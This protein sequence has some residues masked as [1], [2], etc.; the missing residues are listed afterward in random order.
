MAIN[1]LLDFIKTDYKP[2]QDEFKPKY[3]T[4]DN[5][6]SFSSVFEA[7]KKTQE[8]DYNSSAGCINQQK[9]VEYKT[10]SEKPHTT[11]EENFNNKEKTA[12]NIE[13]PEEKTQKTA[14]EAENKDKNPQKEDEKAQ[15]KDEK[16]Q[17]AAKTQAK[18]PSG[19][20]TGKILLENAAVKAEQKVETKE[21]KAETKELKPDQKPAA[22]ADAK[23][24]K[25][26]VK[27]LKPAQKAETK[28][29]GAEAKDAKAETKEVKTEQKVELKELKTDVK[30]LPTAQKKDS[31]EVKAEIARDLTAAEIQK[32]KKDGE[33]NLAMNQKKQDQQAFQQEAKPK[34]VVNQTGTPDSNG[35]KI[36][37]QRSVQ[38]EKILSTKQ[39]DSTQQS[40][41]NQV[42]KASAQLSGSRSEITIALKPENLGRVNINLISHK[43]VL[44]A[45][46]SA[47]NNQ[48]KEMLTK[49]MESLR[50]N[51][52]E[53]G[54]NVGRIVINVQEPSSANNNSDFDQTM[55]K[56]GQNNGSSET[57][58]EAGKNNNHG[59][60]SLENGVDE[61]ETE[62]TA[63]NE[64][65]ETGTESK[66]NGK[67]D[68]TV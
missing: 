43:G 13:K 29:A 28:E 25:V 17:N 54:V 56:F 58:P 22:N 67:V 15:D 48:V 39:P 46:I 65:N 27:D 57:N 66:H 20:T 30:E 59:N 61:F 21:A 5:S 1:Q 36:D 64:E 51:L 37:M 68:Y 41:I 14:K 23:E 35:Q 47:E 31:K 49:G 52:S 60:D 8:Y 44:T 6:N 42:K 33:L 53:Q 55:N 12:Q 19:D 10:T 24:P 40:V 45:Q 7:A 9:E 16:G 4:K 18:E 2:T 62:E 3:C 38:F 32:Q 63:G 50:Q 26:E 11:N 34:I